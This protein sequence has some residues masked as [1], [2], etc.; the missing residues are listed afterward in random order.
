[1]DT[2]EDPTSFSRSALTRSKLAQHMMFFCPRMPVTVRRLLTLCALI[3]VASADARAEDGYSLWLRYQLVS[4]ATLRGEYARAMSQTVV[5]GDSPTL[6]AARDELT[7]GLSGLLGR[8]MRA[9]SGCNRDG[10]ILVGTPTKSS[11][12]AAL[13]FAAELARLGANGFIIRPAVVQHKHVLVV[14]ANDDI[15]V[16][17]GAFALLRELQMQTPVANL[18][19]AT[20]PKIQLR[21]LDHWDNLDRSVERGY[22]GKSL[23]E[24]DS[25][26]GTLSPRYRDYARANASIGINA[27]ALTNVNANAKVLT[28]EYIAKV[29]AIAGVLRPY[30][31]RPFL[32]ARF[33]APIE[34][35]GLKTADPLD[36]AVRAWWQQ[37]I[38]EI[39]VA[40][41]DFGGFVVKANSEGQPGPQDYKR[42]HADGANMFA[43]ALAPHNGVVMWRAFVYSSEVP[44]DRVGQAYDEFKPLDGAFRDNVFVQVKNG[45]LDFQPREPFSPLF[46]AM[47]KTPLMMEFQVTKEYLGQDTH[48]AYLGAEFEEVLRADTYANGK[49][50]TVARVI[51]GSLHGYKHTGITG[52]SNVGTD[53]NWTGSQFNQANWYAYGRLAWNPEASSAAI[54]DEWVRQ[55]FTNDAA[56]VRK[57]VHMMMVSREAVVNYMTPLGLAHIMATGHHYGPAPWARVARAD[58][59]PHYYLKLDSLGVGFDRTATGSNQVAQYFPPVRDRYANL[60][61]VPDSNLLWFHHV[62]WNYQMKS[63]R[64]LWNEMIVHLNAGVDTVRAM[65]RTWNGV[66]SAIDPQRFAEVQSFLAIQEKE[67]RWWRDADLT[68]FQTFSHL[69]IPAAFEQPAHPL[70]YYQSLRCPANRLKPR[71][72]AIP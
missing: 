31:I 8:S 65:Q 48:L 42:T 13:P 23:W 72:D 21:M 16:L 18:A 19:L 59:S 67:A 56:V 40:I 37:K 1:M 41:P 14:A 39:Y 66:R 32:T 43:D 9:A 36:P 15:G 2:T 53:T 51:D 11:T 61:T 33:S 5:E 69:P 68:Y 45:P 71:C 70:A 12:I 3:L 25:L 63:G 38:D 24:W 10:C 20:A 6:A 46:G 62:P 49:G 34:I 29:A 55:T 30:G 4:N 17:Y 52:V 54:A 26:P 64:T 57:I 58:Q 22:A 27:A 28:P 60:A 35:G 47:P 7:R 50:S 44:A